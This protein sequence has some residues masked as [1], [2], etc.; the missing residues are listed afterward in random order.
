MLK[1]PFNQVFENGKEGYLKKQK[2]V[3]QF[4]STLRPE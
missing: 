1:K 2:K 4:C 3:K